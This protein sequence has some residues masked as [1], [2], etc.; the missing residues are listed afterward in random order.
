MLSIPRLIKAIDSRA[1]CTSVWLPT[2]RQLVRLWVQTSGVRSMDVGIL[3]RPHLGGIADVLKHL[4]P[5][6]V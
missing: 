6:L 4:S 2:G 3:S 5:L 1:N